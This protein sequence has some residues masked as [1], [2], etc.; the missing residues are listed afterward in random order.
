MESAFEGGNLAVK[1]PS[2]T[3][4]PGAFYLQRLKLFAGLARALHLLEFFVPV[5]V[6][7]TRVVKR[8]VLRAQRLAPR[9]SK[10]HFPPA[11]KFRLV[12][13]SLLLRALP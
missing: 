2:T 4:Q 3:F 9:H 12:H 5:Q 7:A 8:L 11:L 6:L 13:W 1:L 10:M